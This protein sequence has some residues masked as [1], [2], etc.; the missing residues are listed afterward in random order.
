V[1][2]ASRPPRKCSTLGEGIVIFAVCVATDFRKRKSSTKMPRGRESLPATCI[3]CGLPWDSPFSLWK[4]TVN[5]EAIGFTLSNFTRKSVCQVPRLNS[6]SVTDFRP[7]S[8]CR[9]T[10]SRIA[11][12][13]TSRSVPGE[14][15]LRLAASRAVI[16]SCGRMRLPTWSARKGGLLRALIT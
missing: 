10:T 7:I 4:R 1:S 9:R 12:S 11:A 15:S 14:I 2:I 13:C 8:S 6:P 3:V 5:F 16:S